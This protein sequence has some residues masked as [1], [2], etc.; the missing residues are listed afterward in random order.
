K[1]AAGAFRFRERRIGL[2]RASGAK[3]GGLDADHSVRVFG[4]QD[5][6]SCEIGNLRE[7]H[8]RY[9]GF[10]GSKTTVSRLCSA[11]HDQPYSKSFP[12]PAGGSKISSR[13]S[14]ARFTPIGT[15]S[16][17]TRTSTSTG[18]AGQ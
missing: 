18:L 5:L 6:V 12:R 9:S 1:M 10:C 7:Q 16:S 3:R 15:T 14:L 17:P 13:W 11:S 2:V 4:D 8:G